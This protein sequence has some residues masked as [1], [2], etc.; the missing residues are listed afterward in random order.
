MEHVSNCGDKVAELDEKI[1]TLITKRNLIVNNI[2]KVKSARIYANKALIYWKHNDKRQFAAWRIM[3]ITI[4][5]LLE[6]VEDFIEK[7]EIRQYGETNS[8]RYSYRCRFGSC[9]N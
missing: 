1:E 6:K 3:S 4:N 8:R 5:E 9:N 2:N 7:T